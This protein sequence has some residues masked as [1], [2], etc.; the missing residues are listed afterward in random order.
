M[1]EKTLRHLQCGGIYD[2]LGGGFHRYSTD[3]EWLLPHFEK[4][5]YDQALLVKTLLETYQITKKTGYAQTAKEVLHYVLRD[6]TSPEGAFYSAEDAESEGEEGKFYVWRYEEIQDLLENSSEFF[7]NLY[8]VEK[9]GNFK[10]EATRKITGQ[11]ILHL[12][13]P[14]YEETADIQHDMIE[15]RDRLF[16]YRKQRP[17]PHKD[18]KILSDWNGMMISAFAYAG[19]VL[20]EPL[21]LEA[22]ERSAQFLLDNL[23]IHGELFHRYRQ[24]KV[25]ID[26]FLDD[27]AYV[28]LGFLD[29]YEATFQEKWLYHALDLCQKMN[30][31]FWDETHHGFF[32]SQKQKDTLLMNPKEIY[33]GALPSGNSGAILLLVRLSKLTQDKELEQKVHQFFSAFSSDLMQHPISYPFMLLAL[34]FHFGPAYEI[35]LAGKRDDPLLKRLHQAV[36]EEFLPQ[37]VVVFHPEGESVPQLLEKIP[38]LVNQKMYEDQATAYV[39][40]QQVCQLPTHD[41]QK[42]LEFLKR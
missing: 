39:C 41:V 33:D 7:T 40:Y 25:G 20:N 14:L 35:V 27:Y 1:V 31:R 17:A 2:H 13:R 30:Q 26:G 11:N 38:F 19:R 42:L 28:A 24:Q 8:S 4:M 34:D 37:K 9:L 36:F 12:K 6:M 5:L 22:A 16:Q 15:L 29:L 21:Y 10:E 3:Q 23:F 18:D 32:L